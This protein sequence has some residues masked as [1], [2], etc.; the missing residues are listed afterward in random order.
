M[1]YSITRLFLFFMLPC[2]AWALTPDEALD[3]LMKGNDRYVRGELEHPNRSP[4][5]RE[6]TA[7]GQRPFAIILGCSDSRVAP[8]IIFD[9]GIGDL[10]VVRVAGNVCDPVVLDSI[11]FSALHFD[12]AVILVLGHKNCGAVRAVV[13]GKIAE[14]EAVADRIKPAVQRTQGLV[15]NPVENAVKMNV[16]LVVEQLKATSI[17]NA[18]MQE[19]KISV[20]GGYYDIET[21]RVGIP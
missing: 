3:R 10:F 13:E 17:I 6:E 8:E 19:Q 7:L 15:G 14:I 2:L 20:V 1:Q 12:S 11:E 4:G 9:Q 16:E 21:G 5:R 18:L